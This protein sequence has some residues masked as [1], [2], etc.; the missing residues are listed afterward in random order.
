MNSVLN[1]VEIVLGLGAGVA[2]FVVPAVIALVAGVVGGR[3]ADSKTYDWARENNLDER[4]DET[5]ASTVTERSDAVARVSGLLVR[6]LVY[7]IALLAAVRLL[8]ITE[9][10]SIL[11][12][13]VEL[14]PNGVAAVVLLVA[15]A[16]FARTLKVAVPDLVSG[17]AVVEQ[18]PNTHFGEVVGADGTTVGR[19]TGLIFEYYVYF[20]TLYA[21]AV[22]LTVTSVAGLLQRGLLY[23]P[24][25]V[26]ALVVM[27][28]GSLVADHFATQVK[29][30]DTIDEWMPPS[31]LTGVGQGLIYLFT[32]VVALSVAGVNS[33]VLGVLLLSTV[34]PVGV[35]VALALGRGSE[36]FV[37]DR[38]ES[39]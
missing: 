7:L 6:Y 28:L 39:E 10:Q 38:L 1:I 26:A 32:V 12:R 29:T 17:A 8:R 14:V 15:G 37:A 19:A 5:P 23:A 35:G 33:V 31:F 2:A 3:V 24:T 34:L 16:A 4:A 25:L 18:F 21:I 36:G 9:L 30:V 27:V 22:T 11:Q 20:A 13:G